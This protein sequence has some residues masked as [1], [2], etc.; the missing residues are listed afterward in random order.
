MANICQT[1]IIITGYNICLVVTTSNTDKTTG[2]TTNLVVIASATNIRPQKA[3]TSAKMQYKCCQK[4]NKNKS[5]HKIA[6][7][8]NTMMSSSVGNDDGKHFLQTRRSHVRNWQKLVFIQNLS[9][10]F[11]T[12]IQST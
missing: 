1:Q 3:I 8:T 9:S 7:H 4:Y 10:V 6:G 11:E 12:S 2:Y 5:V